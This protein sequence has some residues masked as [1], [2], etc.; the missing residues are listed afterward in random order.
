VPIYDKEANVKG[1]RL[2]ERFWIVEREKGMLIA[3]PTYLPPSAR[4][5]MHDIDE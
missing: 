5:A 2:G 3:N 1:V 4:P